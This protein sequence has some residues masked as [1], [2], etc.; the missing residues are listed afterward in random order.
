[1]P[2]PNASESQGDAIVKQLEFDLER[3]LKENTSLKVEVAALKEKIILQVPLVE[4]AVAVRGR[5]FET[6]KETRGYGAAYVDVVAAGERAAATGNVRADMAMLRLGYMKSAGSNPV[7][8]QGRS[9]FKPRYEDI[10]FKEFYTRSFDDLLPASKD[11]FSHFSMKMLDICD[12]SA[13][14]AANAGYNSVGINLETDLERFRQ[15][16]VECLGEDRRIS[17]LFPIHQDRYQA[18]DSWPTVDVYLKEMLSIVERV[19]QKHSQRS[20]VDHVPTGLK[21]EKSD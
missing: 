9:D 21:Q 6:A 4:V 1:M 13:T 12:M 14:L 10:L 11:N 20:I 17:K 7:A 8:V 19:I 18:F 3:L 16:A 2:A 15:L 5:F